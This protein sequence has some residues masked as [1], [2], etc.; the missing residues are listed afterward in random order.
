MNHK[1]TGL[2]SDT[3]LGGRTDGM[4]SRQGHVGEQSTLLDLVITVG[5]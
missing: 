3:R 5:A 1:S 4:I 2:G